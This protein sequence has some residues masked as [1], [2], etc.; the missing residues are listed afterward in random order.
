MINYTEHIP[1]T[2][3]LIDKCNHHLKNIKQALNKIDDQLKS[4]SV[5]KLRVLDLEI[6]AQHKLQELTFVLDEME[7]NHARE[8]RKPKNLN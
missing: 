4:L 5:E 3:E 2:K 8:N 1:K 6:H 7:K